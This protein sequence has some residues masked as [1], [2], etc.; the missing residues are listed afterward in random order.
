MTV[1][2]PTATITSP[3]LPLAAVPVARLIDPVSPELD[4]P[5]ANSN[6]PL[7][8]ATPAFAL[9]IT[10]LPEVVCTPAPVDIE[11]YPPPWLLAVDAPAC[12]VVELPTST[13][14]PP[15]N[16]IWPPLP[17]AADPVEM[18]ICPVAPLVEVPVLN[19]K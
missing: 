15:L 16:I 5:V 7:T 4:V 13:P 10:V 18:R 2:E 17:A 1:P 11:M 6:W 14:L 19:D 8:P 12:I 3:A 9:R